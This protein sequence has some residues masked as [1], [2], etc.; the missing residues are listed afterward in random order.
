MRRA[1]IAAAIVA[2]SLSGCT[3][4]PS[5]DA[6]QVDVQVPETNATAVLSTEP[7]KYAGAKG[8]IIRTRHYRVYTTET[9]T[10]I[11]GRLA[12]FLETALAHYRTEFGALPEPKQRMDTYLMDNRAQWERVTRQLM[13]PHAEQLTRIQRGGFAS[14]AIGV[15]YDIGLFDTFAIASHEGWHQYTQRIVR[16]HEGLP[17][18]TWLE[19]GIA[20]YLEGFR[21]EQNVPV[22]NGWINTER[23]DQLRAAHVSKRLLSLEE[24]LNRRPQDFLDRTGPGILDYYAQLWALVHFL[25]EG[26]DGA[27]APAFTSIL[28]EAFGGGMRERLMAAA[29]PREIRQAMTSRTGSLVFEVYLGGDLASLDASYQAFIAQLV[30]PGSRDAIV[31]GRSPFE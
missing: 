16:D 4:A 14:R 25:R 21:W 7:W 18:P 10:V 9:N 6:R 19:E 8:E 12:G 22:Y 5:S 17:L 30:R 24:L 13:G 3:S 11:K 28:E 2:G 1:A 31:A 23:Y 29:E 27:Y 15:Y 26:D 20:A